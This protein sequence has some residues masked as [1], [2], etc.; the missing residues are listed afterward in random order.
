MDLANQ[1][2]TLEQATELKELGIMIDSLFYHCYISYHG[3]WKILMPG[4]GGFDAYIPAY[5]VAELGEMLPRRLHIKGN[6]YEILM[7]IVNHDVWTA[8]SHRLESLYVVSYRMLYSS[9]TYD[10]DAI[11]ASEAQARADMLIHLLKEGIL[12]VEGINKQKGGDDV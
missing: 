10:Y 9:K 12:T 11:S 5:T 1:V 6:E 4:Q 3:E 8:T 2:C 7:R